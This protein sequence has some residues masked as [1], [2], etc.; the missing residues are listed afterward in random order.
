[1][2]N[3]WIDRECHRKAERARELCVEHERWW[4]DDR[5]EVFVDRIVCLANEIYAAREA[6]LNIVNHN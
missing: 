5:N 1:M 4:L 6:E 2:S 3:V